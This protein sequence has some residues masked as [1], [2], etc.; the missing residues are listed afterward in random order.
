MLHPIQ[1]IAHRAFGY[2]AH[3]HVVD[4]MNLLLVRNLHL[5]GTRVKF[6]MP[7]P[8][9]KGRPI[10][11]AANHQSLHDIPM[12]IW[13]LRA[14]HPKFVSKKALGKGIPSVSYNLRHSGA[15]LIDRDDKVQ[16]LRE[17]DKMGELLASKNYSVVIFPEGTR[18]R[19]GEPKEFAVGG[20][21]KLYSKVPNALIVPI[22]INNSWKL[23][24]YGKFP[25]S[26]FENISWYVH[27]AID[28]KGR[29]I[30]EVISELESVSTGAI[31]I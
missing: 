10:I 11:F 22:T 17:L 16:A 6:Q 31:I 27:E 28:P 8:P 23:Y 1:V 21:S 25:M 26:A 4:Y 19:N 2:N 20:I 12:L 5:L 15:A 3:R 9:P 18:S 24:Q 30:K 14:Y 29:D 7:I 13:K